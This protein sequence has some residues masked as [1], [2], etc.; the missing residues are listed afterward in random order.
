MAVARFTVLNANEIAT[1]ADLAPSTVRRWR[2]LLA[3]QQLVRETSY[4][5]QWTLTP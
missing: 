2:P 3:D 1:C 4:V 5:G